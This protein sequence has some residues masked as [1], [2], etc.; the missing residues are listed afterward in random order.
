[1]PFSLWRLLFV[2][3]LGFA[4][5]GC[6]YARLARPSVVGQ[7]DPAV[8]RLINEMP[9]L[10]ASNEATVAE[11]YALG[12]LAHAKPGPDGVMRADIA[13]PP[14]HMLW[15]PAIIVMPHGGPLELHFSNYD[16]TYHMAFLPDNGGREVLSLP[17][18]HG[19]RALIELDEPGFHWFGCP[20]AAHLGR[21]M[22]GLII[23]RGHVPPEARL[24]RPPQP[25]PPGDY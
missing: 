23:V 15:T 25:Q 19:G 17:A 1:M 20:V 5:A 16:Q 8:V 7:L 2:P 21:G 13:V 12:G 11:L 4:V 6:D 10:D 18:Q 9:N 3:L 24:D 22:L 14:L